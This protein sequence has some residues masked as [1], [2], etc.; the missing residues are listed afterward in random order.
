ME[1]KPVCF[2]ISE[3][4]EFTLFLRMHLL[5]DYSLSLYKNDVNMFE[6]LL[7]S[8]PD[9]V[10]LNVDKLSK[11]VVDKLTDLKKWCELHFIPII[12]TVNQL[13][14]Q[15]LIKYF[16]IAD[17]VFF[18]PINL[19]ELVASM[20]KH[21]KKRKNFLSYSFIDSITG[22]FNVE[23]L[24]AELKRQFSDMQR[25][26]E[27]LSVVYLEVKT[28]QVSVIQENELV[29]RFVQ[30]IKQ[31]IR[32]TDFLGHYRGMKEFVLVLPK[33]VRLD[34]EKLMERLKQQLT[35]KEVKPNFLN[36]AILFSA[37]VVEVT[38]PTK[39]PEEWL[40]ILEKFEQ[41][42]EISEAQVIELK[43]VKIAIIDDDRLIREL[44][45]HQL[46]DI[47]ETEF[48]FEIKSY[49]DG[50]QFF[51][52]PWHRQNERF[53]LIIDRIMPKMDGLEILQKIRT[54]Y[55]RKRYLCFMLT[56]K[57]SEEDIALAIQKG[58]N[59]YLTKPFSL[60]ELQVRIKRLLRGTR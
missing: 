15:N 19:F 1:R 46:Q 8:C 59:D 52:D 49:A 29:K 40:S 16:A 34:A 31:S 32:P 35:T 4:F 41:E 5:Q 10:I 33:T 13:E 6:Q 37:K 27:P 14:Q 39:T 7:L 30:F 38:D 24:K 45:V 9:C 47:A 2:V 60:K 42:D 54:E 25:S 12:V 23:C 48:E 17:T 55:D 3:D 11:E 18:H 22:A 44:L 43:K 21:V 53:L 28:E 20:M 57:G 26:F 50:E 58:A 56:S 36:K 51:N